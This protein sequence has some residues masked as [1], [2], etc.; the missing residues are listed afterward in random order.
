MS[1]FAIYQVLPRLFGNYNTTLKP[2]VTIQ[3]NG[4]ENSIH[5]RPNH[6][7]K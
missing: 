6:K 4:A 3:E 1:K 7:K 2:H 5:L